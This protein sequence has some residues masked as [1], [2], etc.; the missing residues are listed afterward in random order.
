MK[1]IKAFLTATALTAMMISACSSAKLKDN[2]LSREEQAQGYEL[3]FDG[4]TLNGW[5]VYNQGK[6][7][8][9]WVAQDGALTCLPGTDA[10]HGDLVTDQEFENYEFQFDWKISK[11]GNSGVFINVVEREDISTAW[12]SGPEYQL[13]DKE[14]QDYVKAMKRPGCLYNFSPQLN[15]AEP[16]SSDEWNHSVIKQ[17]HG[18]IEFMLNGIVTAKQDFSTADWKAAVANS[19]FKHFPEFGKQ[20]KGRIALQ[21]W[22]KGVAFKNLKIR[23]LEK[24]AAL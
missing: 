23:K 4:K 18:K 15:P 12:S 2:E 24:T 7:S 19:S 22:N 3:L 1:K 20:I 17:Q 11:E 16:K 13:L 10:R 5:H 21:D 9:S 8:S 14:H 6:I